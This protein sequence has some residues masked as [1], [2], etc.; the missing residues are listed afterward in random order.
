M[1][2][3]TISDSS[4]MK[5]TRNT[6]SS[7]LLAGRLNWI[8]V[9]AYRKHFDKCMNGVTVQETVQLDKKRNRPLITSVSDNSGW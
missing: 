7:I 5:L 2:R 9:S 3:P 1:H 6:K 8:R 4:Y